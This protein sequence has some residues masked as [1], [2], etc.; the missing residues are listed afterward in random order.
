MDYSRVICDNFIENRKTT[1]SYDKRK[2]FLRYIQMSFPL[3]S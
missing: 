2:Q 1:H 3:L